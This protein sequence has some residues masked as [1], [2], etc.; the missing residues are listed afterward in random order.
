MD[1]LSKVRNIERWLKMEN[2][3]ERLLK[4][5]N[6]GR[7]LRGICTEYQNALVLRIVKY[8]LQVFVS[9]PSV[10]SAD[11]NLAVQTFELIFRFVHLQLIINLSSVYF[12]TQLGMLQWLFRKT[13]Q[14]ACN[15]SLSQHLVSSQSFDFR[16]SDKPEYCRLQYNL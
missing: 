4:M 1:R 12:F 15:I 5:E 14:E 2:M 7:L 13:N 11:K 10:S 6:M 16:S 9:H 3:G 8:L